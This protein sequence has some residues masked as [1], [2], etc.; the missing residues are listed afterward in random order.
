M[1][2]IYYGA[3][4]TG[5]TTA[6]MDAVTERAIAGQPT[7]VIVPEQFTFE[8]ERMLCDRMGC[9]LFNNGSAEVL[10]LS[11]LN[12]R[13]F[14]EC[15]DTLSPA[16]ADSTMKNALMY[17]ALKKLSDG[18]QLTYYRRQAK[19]PTFVNTALSA[20]AELICSGITPE[21]LGNV[22]PTAP[23]GMRDKLTDLWSIYTEYITLIENHN[24]R[25]GMLDAYAAAEA[26]QRHGF[27]KGM[28]VYFDEFESFTGDQYSIVEA[29][30]SQSEETVFSLTSDDLYSTVTGPYKSVG[31]TA[32]SVEHAAQHYGKKCVKRKFTEYLRFS[33]PALVHLADNLMRAKVKVYDGNADCVTLVTA[34]D[35]YAQCEY[36]CAEIRRLVCET[37]MELHFSDIAILSRNMDETLSVLE[38]ALARFQIPFYSDKKPTAAHKPLIM[39]TVAAIQ[40]ASSDKISTETLLRCLKTGIPDITAEETAE[41]ENFCYKWDIDGELWD[42]DFP[43]DF[44]EEKASMRQEFIRANELKDKALAPIKAL[45]EKLKQA[46]SGDEICAAL[47]ELIENTG[48]QRRL[49]IQLFSSEN[50]GS[51]FEEMS[52]ELR[53]NRRIIAD[54]NGILSSLEHILAG[55]DISPAD[56]REILR[57]A[58]DEIT[59]SVPPQTLDAVSAQQ[60][61]TARLSG[62]RVVFVIDAQEG[63][64]PFTDVKESSFTGREAEF[65]SS[66]GLNLFSSALSRLAEERFAAFKAITCSSDMVYIV[67]PMT[68]F[69]EKP[70]YKASLVQKISAMLP[71]ARRIS[72]EDLPLLFYCATEESA[73]SAAVRCISVNPTPEYLAV[74]GVLEKNDVYRKR[75]EYLDTLKDSGLTRQL[76]TVR[77]T[78]CIE[79]ICGNALQVSPSA[80]EDY[81]KCPF[82]YYCKNVL[83]LRP[84]EKKEL[85]AAEYGNVAHYVLC[86]MLKKYI[87][88]DTRKFINLSRE[89]LEND[90]ALFSDEYIE[91]E[92]AG[93]FAKKN[94]FDFFLDLLR[95][96]LL[97]VLLNMQEEFS[98]SDFVP[99]EFEASVGVRRYDPSKVGNDGGTPVL[100]D[101]DDIHKVSFCGTADR[102]DIY[103]SEDGSY[104]R[105]LDYK[106]GRKEL[107]MRQLAFGINM[108]MFMYLFVL[109]DKTAGKYKDSTPAGVLYYHIDLPDQLKKRSVED[110]E[111]VKYKSDSLKM[112]GAISDNPKIIK[113]MEHGMAGKFV[114][115]PEVDKKSIFMN[116][117]IEEGLR[118]HSAEMLKDMGK[119]I[120]EGNIPA[121]PLSDSGICTE[122]CKYCSFAQICSF[123]GKYE[124]YTP[125][126]ENENKII[127]EIFGEEE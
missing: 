29:I 127:S 60:L 76:H 53:E 82:M 108:Q 75:F 25:D 97:D 96:T 81:R 33:S 10:S 73:Y 61:K 98:Q 74:R 84:N 30:I 91:R 39:Y 115:V 55:R 44:P 42:S 35:P 126:K 66:N 122:P 118:K 104:I 6:V 113:A 124:T 120:F 36:I 64:L 92:L 16:A 40:L 65:L 95:R 62:T 43:T 59:L 50:D 38:S 52:A 3:S 119:N 57:L 54:L 85:N 22:L 103:N 7:L 123:G 14:D 106:T 24:L 31:T 21:L 79:R 17:T 41:L 87:D 23:E 80:F 13:I 8:Y 117:R 47:R 15:N 93:R 94:S 78:S 49:D 12:K 20:V 90:I 28:Y 1:V 112:F 51:P 70:L 109:T 114:P 111:L 63:M 89:A 4:G 58:A 32:S 45:S 48:V 77:N 26:A 72:T 37:D 125:D 100:I 69:A 67:S 102:V 107:N 110:E 27:F 46:K 121:I 18:G 5:K 9:R 105:V 101:I 86:A 19:R 68:D 2:T 34:P 56:F 99:T 88:G 116:S 71:K 11:R 83:H